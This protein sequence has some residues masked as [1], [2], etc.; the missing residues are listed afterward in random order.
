MCRATDLLGH[1]DTEEEAIESCLLGHTPGLAS[2]A[3]YLSGAHLQ[4]VDKIGLDTLRSLVLRISTPAGSVR[5][6]PG[7]PAR[8]PPRPLAERAPAA[9]FTNSCRS[10]ASMVSA[11]PSL[12]SESHANRR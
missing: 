4:V 8:R 3:R 9:S 11:R 5:A 7:L 12:R 1:V 2:E 10:H 6:F